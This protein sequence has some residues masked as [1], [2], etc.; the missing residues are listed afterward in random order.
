MP[1]RPLNMIFSTDL[2]D[3]R[4][5]AMKARERRFNLSH[6]FGDLTEC[7]RLAQEQRNTDRLAAYKRKRATVL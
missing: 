5:D 3:S 2:Y 7:Q 1:A 4:I 6:R